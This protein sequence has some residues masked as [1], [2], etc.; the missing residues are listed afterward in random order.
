MHRTGNFLHRILKEPYAL[1][2]R[3]KT[4]F[5]NNNSKTRGNLNMYTYSAKVKRVIDGDSV[6]FEWVDLGLHTFIHHES[7]R[8]FAIDT[9]EKRGG[10]KETKALG[11][12]ATEF[13]QER[14]P[15]GKEVVIKTELDRTGKFG[16][17]LATIYHQGLSK[18]SLNKLLLERKLAVP[19]HGQSKS[20]LL[21]L[22]MANYRHWQKTIEKRQ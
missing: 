16:R 14:L 2:L 15:A 13:V 21:P 12:L 19:Y 1:W 6:V 3:L 17:I 9:A 20:E 5:Y 18:K 10:S 7:C 8:L 4:L 22:H 11:L